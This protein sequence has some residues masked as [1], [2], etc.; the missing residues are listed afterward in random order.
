MRLSAS[1][2]PASASATGTPFIIGNEVSGPGA[3]AR[4]TSK[5]FRRLMPESIPNRSSRSST[6]MAATARPTASP[7]RE[8]L[9][10][11]T[12]ARPRAV[13]HKAVIGL[14]VA[15]PEPQL[16][17]IGGAIHQL[18]SDAA[19]IATAAKPA[20]WLACCLFRLRTR[21]KSVMWAP[22]KPAGAP[23]PVVEPVRRRFQH[24]CLREPDYVFAKIYCRSR[25]NWA[26]PGHRRPCRPQTSPAGSPQQAVVAADRPSRLFRTRRSTA[27]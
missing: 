10:G 3:L 22:G 19:A 16:D 5:L 1:E 9:P 6:A 27:A 13:R 25:N 4:G 18:M 23:G 26:A 12:S 8:F 7:N 24:K 15:K 17:S 14:M 20:T 11:Y 21:A 2:A